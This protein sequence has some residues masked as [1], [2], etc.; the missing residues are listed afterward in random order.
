MTSNEQ[1]ITI[2]KNIKETDTPFYRPI[3][4]ILSRIKDGSSKELVKKIRAEKNKS[5]RN[6]LKKQLPAICFS[7]VFSKRNDSSIQEHSGFMCLDFDN[8]EKRKEMLSDKENLQ[9]NRYVYSVFISPSGQG[10]KVIVKIPNDAENPDTNLA[11][12][13]NITNYATFV[14]QNIYNSFL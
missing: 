5:E 3:D 4:T 2:F 7:G 11:H 14:T 6:E 8:Y 13:G 9:K 10:L 1:N 12:L